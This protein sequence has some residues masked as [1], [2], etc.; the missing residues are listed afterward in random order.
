M[1][2]GKDSR[3]TIILE[4]TRCIQNRVNKTSIGISQYITQKNR[5]NTPKRLELK[6][7]CTSC[8]KHTIHAEI[9]N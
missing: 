5:Y 4:C 2:R 7:F 9:K 3:V 6:K 8:Y 1:A